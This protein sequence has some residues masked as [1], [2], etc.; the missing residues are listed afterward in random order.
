MLSIYKKA[1]LEVVGLTACDTERTQHT[2]LQ[3][4][5]AEKHMVSSGSS[6]TSRL[7]ERP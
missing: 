5:R 1:F 4:S 6:L 3:R 7:E 2:F